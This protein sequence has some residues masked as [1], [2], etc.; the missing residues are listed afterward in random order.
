MTYAVERERFIVAMKSE[1]MPEEIAR[2]ILRHANTVRRLS[3]AECNGDYPCDN[4]ERKVEFCSRCEAGYAKGSLLRDYTVKM[5][6]PP[7][8]CPNCRAQDLIAQWCDKASAPICPYCGKPGERLAQTRGQAVPDDL[9][10]YQ[11]SGDETRREGDRF[12]RWSRH[13]FVP[14][15]QGDP[16][17]ACVKLKVPS[18]K[19]DDMGR[20]GMCVPTR[21]Y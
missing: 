14:I 18:G 9:N 6:R 1:G 10:L 17:G 4:G 16:R 15:F 11:C 7:L 21:R 12:H 5:G 19:T 8:I 2:R 13:S 20:E 3:V